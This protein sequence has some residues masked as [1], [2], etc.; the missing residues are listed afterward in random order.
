MVVPRDGAALRVGT[1]LLD[2]GAAQNLLATRPRAVSPRLPGARPRREDDGSHGAQSRRDNELFQVLW[3]GNGTRASRC[4]LEPE[5][6][7]GEVTRSQGETT[8]Q[9]EALGVIGC[10]SW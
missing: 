2:L 1:C 5:R 9:R 7:V 6:R 10:S 4:R 8:R 3:I